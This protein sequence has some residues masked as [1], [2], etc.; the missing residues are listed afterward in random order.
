[1]K[2]L[3][4]LIFGIIPDW[5]ILHLDLDQRLHVLGGFFDVLKLAC[6]LRTSKGPLCDKPTSHLLTK[7][8]S[9]PKQAD[10]QLGLLGLLKSAAS[11][12][13]GSTCF[14]PLLYHSKYVSQ[15]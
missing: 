5:I 14:N 7:Y 2:N 13:L 15:D 9:V 11:E 1:M 3:S 10:L 6:S 4:Y 12:N 8:D